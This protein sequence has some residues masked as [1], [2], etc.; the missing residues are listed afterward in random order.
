MTTTKKRQS[1]EDKGIKYIITKLLLGSALGIAV[2]FMLLSVA[3][4]F[5]LKNSVDSKI[6]P[7]ISLFIAAISS[8][9]SSFVAVRPIR[10]N[11]ILMGICASLPLIITICIAVFFESGGNIGVITVVMTVS[12]IICA[13]IGGI[14]AVNK[15]KR[16]R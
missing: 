2:F 10:K 6:F 8:F 11:G 9:F 12:M 15:K 14:I 5:V 1:Q 4:L 7:I 3:S 16:S 13:A